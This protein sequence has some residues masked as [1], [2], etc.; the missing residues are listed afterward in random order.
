MNKFDKKMIKVTAISTSCLDYYHDKPKNIDLIR[1]KI[2]IDNKEYIDGQDI[3]AL[4]FY[5]KLNNNSK[6]SVKTSQPS[7]GDLVNYFEKISQKYEKVFIPT[8]SKKLRGTYNTI[9]QAQK[10]VKEKIKVIPYDTNTIS[11]S[12]GFFALESERL[13][14]KGNSVEE[15]TK[16]LDFFKKNNTIFFMVGCLKR[17]IK[18]GRLNKT[19]GFLGRLF[20]IKPILQLDNQGQI[21]IIDKKIKL[22]NAFY[23]IIN[24]IRNYTKDKKFLIHILFTN[25]DDGLKNK[26]QLILKK[27]LQIND[28]IEIPISPSIGVHLGANVIGVGII[29]K[30]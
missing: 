24:N 25:H 4:D 9:I 22:D 18:S 21:K 19:K 15:V 17:L 8:L 7:L 1:I 30:N 10:M 29:L 27:E 11:F 13:F 20:R 14:S 6:I 16:Y 28:I 5:N 26:F 23:S 2:L 12:E 3:T